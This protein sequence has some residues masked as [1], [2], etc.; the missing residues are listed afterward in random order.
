MTR[1]EINMW[2]CRGQERHRRS[3]AA[4]LLERRLCCRT[5]PTSPPHRSNEPLSAPP[6]PRGSQFPTK[7][8]P[9]SLADNRLLPIRSPTQSGDVRVGQSSCGRTEEITVDLRRCLN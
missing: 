6:P 2:R 1:T 7:M 4:V 9:L 5:G 3:N 8:L